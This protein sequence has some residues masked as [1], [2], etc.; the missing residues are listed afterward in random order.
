MSE[1]PAPYTVTPVDP[2]THEEL[3]DRGVPLAEFAKHQA[4][5][6]GYRELSR[7]EIG[8]INSVKELEETCLGAIRRLEDDASY[9]PRWIAIGK[10]H[11]QQGFMALCR[12]IARP[13]EK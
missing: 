11:I 10:T 8:H 9:D 12:A 1:E 5:I 4:Q 6:K 7:R 3:P 2:V 13:D